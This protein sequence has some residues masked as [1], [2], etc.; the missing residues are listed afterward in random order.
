MTTL[1][2]T[3]HLTEFYGSGLEKRILAKMPLTLIKLSL[4]ALTLPGT[5]AILLHLLSSQ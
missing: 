4:R 3:S 2:L 1:K 5:L